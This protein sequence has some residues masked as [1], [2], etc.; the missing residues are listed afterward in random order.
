MPKDK[1]KSYVA[2]TEQDNVDSKAIKACVDLKE[3][4]LEIVNIF[5]RTGM[6]DS[7]EKLP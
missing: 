1:A 3:L 7:D 2:H 6:H 4:T 5:I